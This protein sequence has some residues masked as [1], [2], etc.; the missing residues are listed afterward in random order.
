MIRTLVKI[1]LRAL[2]AGMLSQTR[3][4]KKS[5]KGMAILFAVLFLYV[6]AVIAGLMCLSFSQLAPVYH[7]AGLDWL[8]YA[9]AGLMCL[10]L[11]LFGSV[12]MT[13][14]QLYDARDND[15]LLSMPIPPRTILLS[16]MLPLL[17]ITLVFCALVMVPAMVMYGVLVEF[18]FGNVMFQLLALAGI[19]LLS[20]A[21]SCLL[22]WGMH[23][24]LARMNRSLASLLYM[25]VFLAVYF[26]LYSRAGTLLGAIA[27]QGGAIGA[28]VK[29]WV[30]PL[31]AMG[32]GCDGDVLLLMAFSAVCAAVFGGIYWLLSVTFLRTATSRRS[33]KKRKLDMGGM[34]VGNATQAILYKEWRHFLG[35]PVYLTNLGL[36]IL[37]TAGIAVAG[38]VFRGKLMGILDTYAG[39]GLDLTGYIPLLVCG[40][41][42][43]LNA[44]M[45]LSAPSVS[46]EGKN[47]WV[48]KS[49]P[50]STKEILMAKLKFHCLLNTPVIMLAGLVLAAAYGCGV[51]EILLCA[52]VPGLLTVLCGLVGMIFG[53]KWARLDW[54]N[55]TYPV[56]QGMAAGLTMLAMMGLPLVL[57]GCYFALKAVLEPWMFLALCAVAVAAACAGLYRLLIT[58]GVRRWERL[59]G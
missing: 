15:L 42:G 19:V 59:Q 39:L 33:G 57:A 51:P 35:S 40:M 4:K 7:A 13:Q 11:S 20:Q 34:K 54:L 47:L 14:S 46:L 43:F 50:V 44:M 55:E 8:Y 58:W 9:L 25:V 52:L 36:G 5:G 1:R 18:S 41:L 56:K 23:L 22:G 21:L 48:L 38:V 3:Q 31:Y 29:T 32:R 16:R 28:A 12:F 17:G 45:C 30:W 24:L 37:M 6:G 49:M 26:G 10:A 27:T 53:L 2:L